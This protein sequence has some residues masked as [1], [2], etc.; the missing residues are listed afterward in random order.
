M[1]EYLVIMNRLLAG[2]RVTWNTKYIQIP[3]AKLPLLPPAPIPIYINAR[4]PEMLEAAG[5]LVKGA[6]LSI[7]TP[8]WVREFAIPHLKKGAVK[9]GRPMEEVDITYHPI[10][11]LSDD[12]DQALRAARRALSGY[13]EN[14]E[15]TV[16]LRDYGF[17]DEVRAIEEAKTAGRPV[18]PSDPLVEA[19][20]LVGSPEAVGKRLR[21]YLQAGV[22]LPIL[23]PQPLDS[24][25]SYLAAED[26]VR[27]L[28]QVLG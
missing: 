16:L 27:N 20:A 12:H 14:P 26:A 6:N 10:L 15:T 22:R 8:Q 13:F 9:A 11:C 24:Q 4:M 3:E 1:R 19:I 25:G 7:A 28:V 21:E 2:E 23:R 17:A 5:E 18:E